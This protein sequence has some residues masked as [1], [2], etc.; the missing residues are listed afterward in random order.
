M[1]CTIK[2]ISIHNEILQNMKEVEAKK[3][4]NN[5]SQGMNFVFLTGNI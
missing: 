5:E 1:S 4:E 3:K 2:T